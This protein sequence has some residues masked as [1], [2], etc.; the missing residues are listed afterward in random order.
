MTQPMPEKLTE[1]LYIRVGKTLKK[2]IIKLAGKQRP[3]EFIRTLLF[4]RTKEKS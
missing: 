2:N 1:V 4:E 3:T